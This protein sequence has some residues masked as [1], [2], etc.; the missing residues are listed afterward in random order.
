MTL[1]VV[2]LWQSLAV[3]VEKAAYT[4]ISV[5]CNTCISTSM[6]FIMLFA[7]ENAMSKEVGSV[8]KRQSVE[9]VL[10]LHRH[11]EWSSYP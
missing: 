8:L 9:S 5:S 7:F 10:E 1:S 11:D 2:Q 6:P 3:M 4:I